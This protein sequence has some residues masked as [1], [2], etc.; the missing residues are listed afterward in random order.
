[1]ALVSLSLMNIFLALNVRFPRET[2]FQASTF[3]NPRLVYAYLWVVFGSIL[4]TETGLFQAIFSTVPLS[5]YQW[6]LCV[7]PGVVL[8]GM[9]EVDKASLRRRTR[10]EGAAPA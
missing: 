8:L 6:L 9:G 1:M 7:V 2:A 5:P 4:M 3:S 10:N